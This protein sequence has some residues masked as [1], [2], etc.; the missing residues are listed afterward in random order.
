MYRTSFSYTVTS[1][2]VWLINPN[3]RISGPPRLPV[4][5]GSPHLGRDPRSALLQD[6]AAC[7]WISAF[8]CQ[9]ASYFAVRMARRSELVGKALLPGLYDLYALTCGSCRTLREFFH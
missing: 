2:C 5:Q 9:T 4:E 1:K 6:L 7:A 3:H 8:A